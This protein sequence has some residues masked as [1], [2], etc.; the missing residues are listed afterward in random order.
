MPTIQKTKTK[1]K[2]K[3]KGNDHVNIIDPS[4]YLP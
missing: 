2:K 4:V 1:T 3:G